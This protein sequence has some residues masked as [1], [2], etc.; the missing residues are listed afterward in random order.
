M[1]DAFPNAT[2]PFYLDLGLPLKVNLAVAWLALCLWKQ[3]WFVTMKGKT[4]M[5]KYVVNSVNCLF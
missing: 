5:W 1:P 2:I 4:C 3:T